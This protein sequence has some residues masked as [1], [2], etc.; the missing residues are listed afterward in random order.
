MPGTIPHDATLPEVVEKISHFHAM[1]AVPID[2]AFLLIG[3]FANDK[4][5]KKVN[6]GAGV[7]RTEE[8]EPWPLP[9]V[10][11]AEAKLHALANPSRHEYLSIAGDIPFLDLARDLVF[12][13]SKEDVVDKSRIAS[14]Q[15]ISGTGANHLGALFLSRQ[16]KPRRV[17]LADPTWIN[18]HGIWE[19]VQVESALYPYYDASTRSFDFDGMIRTLEERAQKGDVIL[20]QACAHNPTGLDPTKEQWKAIAELCQK[21]GI[22]PFFDCAYQGFA[23]GSPEEDSWAVQY[24]LGLDMEMCVAQSFSKNFGLYGQRVGAYHVVLSKSAAQARDAVF[25]N[26]CHLIRGEFSMA[27]RGGAGLVKEVLSSKEMYLEW[28]DNLTVMSGRI[29]SMRQQ[30]YDGLVALG[31]PGTWEHIINQVRIYTCPPTSF[32]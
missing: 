6:L 27:P 15:T 18:H 7:Y 5:P 12:G 4:H 11:K 3:L 8:G 30:L 24:F 1:P 9:V 10:E 23:S 19:L 32:A 25:N 17:W 31:T 14:V 16:L 2:E 20:L 26:L 29:K 22:F 28:L 13:L 21:R